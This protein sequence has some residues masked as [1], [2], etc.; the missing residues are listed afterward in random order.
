M[1]R[2]LLAAIALLLAGCAAGDASAPAAGA[3]E[4]RYRAT[5]TV[6]QSRDHGRTF[7]NNDIWFQMRQLGRVSPQTVAVVGR[8]ATLNQDVAP[9]APTQLPKPVPSGAH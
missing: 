3:R 1:R 2:L 8:P 7:A 4:R 6:L 9:F 5:A